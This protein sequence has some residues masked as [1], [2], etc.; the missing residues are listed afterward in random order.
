MRTAL[1][2][3]ISL[4]W[5][6]L[7]SFPV[8]GEGVYTPTNEWS[9]SF[10]TGACESA[11]ALGTDGRK[12]WENVEEG[13]I[14]NSAAAIADASICFLSYIGPLGS[15][16]FEHGLR[17]P[18]YLNGCCHGSPAVSPTGTIYAPDNSASNQGAGLAAWCASVPLGPAA[19]SKFGGNARNTGSIRDMAH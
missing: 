4:T 11:P 5:L 18:Y 1:G 6:M 13:L 14:A 10:R 12:K 17:W 16:H 9:V 7:L 15:R 19:W 2:L 8:R 3:I